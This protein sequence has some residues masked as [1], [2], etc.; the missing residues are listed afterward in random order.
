MLQFTLVE[1]HTRNATTGLLKHGYD[2]SFTAVWAQKPTGS[3]PEVWDRALGWYTMALLDVLD[4]FPT[5]HPGAAKLQGYFTRVMKAVKNAADPATGAWWLVMSQPGRK[6]NY[7]ESSGSAMFVYSLLKGIRVGLLDKATYFPAA[8]RAYQYIVDAFV[9]EKSNG[10]LYWE[11]TVQVGSLSGNGTFDVSLSYQ[12][13]RAV[14]IVTDSL[15]YYISVGLN[16]NDLKGLGP[17]I[18]ASY[19]YELATA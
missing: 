12:H 4:H 8:E 10:T 16:E 3:S 13:R 9:E 6:G 17:F 15:Q 19:E 1:D 11:G 5:H 7:I 14:S 2:E 18:Y